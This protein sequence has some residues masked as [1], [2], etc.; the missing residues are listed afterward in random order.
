MALPAVASPA[1][2]PSDYCCDTLSKIADRIRTVAM[3]GLCSCLDGSCA[4]RRF[5]SYITVGQRVEDPLGDS[6]VVHMLRFRPAPMSTASGRLL[7]VAAFV[8]DLRVQLLENGWPTIETNEMTNQIIAPDSDMIH[9][10]AL[11]AMGH[12]EKMY[13]AVVNAIQRNEM[14][15]GPDNRHIGVVEAGDL[16][17]IQ[18]SA[19]MIGFAFNVRVQTVLS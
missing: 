9:G 1:D 7:N 11:H 6:L 18:P 14:F 2:I 17:P 4:D 15:V 19:Y 3:A 10:L 12:G 13:R 16:E 5:R 8:T